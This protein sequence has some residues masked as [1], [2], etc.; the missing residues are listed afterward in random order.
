MKRKGYG[1]LMIIKGRCTDPFFFQIF[2]TIPQENIMVFRQCSPYQA[3]IGKIYLIK[4]HF[5]PPATA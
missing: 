1:Y 5:V 2:S 3:V 4:Q